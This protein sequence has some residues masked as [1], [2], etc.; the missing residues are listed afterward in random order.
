MIY[1]GL[2]L[3]EIQGRKGIG[4][5]VSNAVKPICMMKNKQ[6]ANII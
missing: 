4:V 3:E 2:D 1:F 5:I 6:R